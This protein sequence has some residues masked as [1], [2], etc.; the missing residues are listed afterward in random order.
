MYIFNRSISAN[1][2]QLMEATAA[3]VE[4]A[5]MA[6][7]IGGIE[8][9]VFG[10]VFGTPVNT[11]AWSSLVESQAQLQEAT[12]KLLGNAEYLAWVDSH[13]DLFESAA[14][15]RLSSVV[16]T[17]F[18]GPKR[19]YGILAATASAGKVGEAVEFG[20][21]AQ[22]LVSQLSGL[23]SAF[24]MEV[25]GA[26]GAVVWL[27]GA[28]SMAELDALQQLQMSSAE[29]QALG[30]EAGSLFIEGSGANSL[31]QRIA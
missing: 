8:V 22:Q 18:T 19:F 7:K 1:R 20:V 31:I 28:D 4:V 25:Y 17:T 12:E 3:A 13:G 11:I 26:Y 10:S 5:A 24:A 21:R 9:S 15:D 27:T 23:E 2:S 30:V 6:T 16:S 29:Y 14:N